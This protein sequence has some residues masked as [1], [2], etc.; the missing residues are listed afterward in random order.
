MLRR[1]FFMLPAIA[2]IQDQGP[3]KI[4]TGRVSGCE[5]QIPHYVRDDEGRHCVRDD[6]GSGQFD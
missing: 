4:D 5:Q 2:Q 1:R 6:A 3:V